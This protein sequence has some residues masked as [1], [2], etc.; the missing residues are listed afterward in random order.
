MGRRNTRKLRNAKQ[1]KIR[2]ALFTEGLV[3]N[4]ST[5]SYCVN[6]CVPAM[7]LFRSNL[8]AKI[9]REYSPSTS[10][11]NDAA[12]STKRFS[13]LMLISIKS[14]MRFCGNVSLLLPLMRSLPTHASNYGCCGIP[15]TDERIQKHA[16]ASD[17]RAAADSSE[18][19]TSPQGFRL[20][21]SPRPSN[22]HNKPGRP[23]CQTR[24]ARTLPRPC[25]GSSN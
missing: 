2:Y 16:T 3:M 7:Q 17:S 5:L 20:L 14:L 12:I 6:T 24:R 11:R 8:S 10:R 9:L 25:P 15:L 13:S 18:T 1:L 23:S 21:A 19:R 4:V 22:E